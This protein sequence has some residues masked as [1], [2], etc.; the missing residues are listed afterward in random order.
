MLKRP[1]SACRPAEVMG[2]LGTAGP[3]VIRFVSPRLVD[4][5][6]QAV[7]GPGFDCATRSQ[8]ARP[9][10]SIGANDRARFPVRLRP[11]V[12]SVMAPGC[13]CSARGTGRDL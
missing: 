6:A 7:A 9:A 13:N 11:C 5:C 4:P 3:P 12:F 1:E 2:R 10:E 8:R